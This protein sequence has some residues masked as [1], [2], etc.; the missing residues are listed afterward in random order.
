[1][2]LL[3]YHPKV[4]TLV[5]IHNTLRPPSRMVLYS[6]DHGLQITVL[7]QIIMFILFLQN[8]YLPF[9]MSILCAPRTFTIYEL[10]QPHH[11]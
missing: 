10:D 8:H 5:M 4:E 7:V 6:T 3:C 1:M 9:R 2:I 11:K